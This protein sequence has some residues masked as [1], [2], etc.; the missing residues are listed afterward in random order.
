VIL[1]GDMTSQFLFLDD[2]TRSFRD[3]LL[4]LYGEWVVFQ[5]CP[6]RNIRPLLGLWI[7]YSCYEISYELYR[8]EV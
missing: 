5:N 2:V 7:K 1:P 8:Q 4:H 3:N 6:P